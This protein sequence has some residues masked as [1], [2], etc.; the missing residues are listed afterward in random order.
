MT[1]R[2]SAR[3]T[4]RMTA[5]IPRSVRLVTVLAASLLVSACGAGA[6]PAPISSV[7]PGP[8]QAVSASQAATAVAIDQALSGVGLRSTPAQLA[9]R[10]GESPKLA[11]APRTVV[12]AVLPND[13][14]H[15]MIVIYDFPDAGSA[16]AAGTEMAGYL[17]SGQGRIQFLPDALFSLR[18]VGSTVVFFSWS[19]ANSPDPH[20]ADIA[21]ALQ[22]MGTEIPIGR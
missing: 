11:V 5:S 22:G 16:L 4:A 10:P 18:Q 21:T 15:G 19:P 13:Q 12:Q 2:T 3:M 17:R 7:V 6:R 14:T 20:T 9:F 8:T 1:T